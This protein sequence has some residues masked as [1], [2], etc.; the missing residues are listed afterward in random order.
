MAG[1]KYATTILWTFDR[2]TQNLPLKQILSIIEKK[3]VIKGWKPDEK[4]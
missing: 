1:L 3:H 4:G 2:K